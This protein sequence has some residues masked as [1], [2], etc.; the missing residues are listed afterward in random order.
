MGFFSKFIG[1][2][3]P[4]MTTFERAIIGLM[5]LCTVS[6]IVVATSAPNEIVPQSPKASF[7]SVDV[8]META[9]GTAAAVRLYKTKDI[10]YLTVGS[11]SNTF[12]TL[13]YNFDTVR[14]EGASVPRVFVVNMPHDMPQIRAAETRKR[15]FFKTVLPLVLKA[16]DDILQER[17]RLLRIQAD[18]ARTGKLV[19]ADRLW[20]A[21][22]SERYKV[23]RHNIAEM[24]HRADIIPPSLALAQAAEESGWGTSRFALEGNA[25]FG[26]WT[27][28]VKGAL[29][30]KNRDSGKAHRVRAFPSLLGAVQAYVRNLNTHKAYRQFRQ[31]RQAMRQSGQH[32]V[33][34]ELARTLSSYSQ[35]G[36][37]YVRT[38]ELII[39][40]NQLQSLDKARLGGKT[41]SLSGQ[42][43]I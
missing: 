27:F 26:Q 11:L 42:P 31:E 13:D 10:N 30:P 41:V 12:S 36:N 24:I 20:L 19:A 40:S 33:G 9:S 28:A 8:N 7:V 4:K 2:V 16:N 35:R 43:V 32:L 3:N 1:A 22:L 14:D 34:M 37:K 39:N 15:I 17:K 25:L 18:K 29:V 38:I 5:G 6:L 23:S 21:A